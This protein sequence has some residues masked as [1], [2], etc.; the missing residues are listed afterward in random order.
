M[1]RHLDDASLD[2]DGH[3]DVAEDMDDLAQTAALE[4][5]RTPERHA[6]QQPREI[7]IQRRSA[8]SLAGASS[9]GLRG[10]LPEACSACMAVRWFRSLMAWADA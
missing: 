5:R 9:S 1:R 7:G 6:R 8:L 3:P 2:A 10:E 4:Q